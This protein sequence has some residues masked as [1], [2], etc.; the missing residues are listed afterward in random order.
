MTD[1]PTID[2]DLDGVVY[3]TFS[4]VVSD[5]IFHDSF[6]RY[7]RQATTWNFPAIDWNMS[8]AE[9]NGWVIKGLE[10]EY[11]FREGFPVNGAVDG[12]RALDDAGF[13]IR[14][15]TQRLGWPMFHARIIANTSAWLEQWRIPYH[16]IWFQ[17]KGDVKNTDGAWLLDDRPENVGQHR[18]G[19]LFAQAHNW[20]VVEAMQGD[21]NCR[22]VQGWDE[23]V[24][25]VTP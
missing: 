22:V 20:K 10:A 1:R 21:G 5:F 3:P 11:I 16:S 17:G 14:I 23:F 7:P 15:V 4:E 25:M 6:K 13:R 24:E 9:F 12:M 19:V 8:D 2:I 18:N